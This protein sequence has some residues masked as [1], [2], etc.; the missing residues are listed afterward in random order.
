MNL[1]RVARIIPKEEHHFKH[2]EHRCSQSEQEIV[3]KC[4]P[5]VLEK[6]VPNELHNPAESVS[7]ADDLEM[8]I[9]ELIEERVAE[10]IPREIYRKTYQTYHKVELYV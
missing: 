8:L 4:R 6:S 3:H 1:P 2:H 10:H 9:S 5:S 7:S